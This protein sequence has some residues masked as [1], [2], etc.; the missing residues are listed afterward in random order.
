MQWSATSKKTQSVSHSHYEL[1]GCKVEEELKDTVRNGVATG[2]L[3]IDF[4]GSTNYS[5]G[6]SYAAQ[7]Q[8]SIDKTET[9][10]K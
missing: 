8:R 10:C 2:T 4:S 7:I 6:P 5:V 3:T 1:D 9:D